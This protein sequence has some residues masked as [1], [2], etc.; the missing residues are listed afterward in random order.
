MTSAVSFVLCVL[1]GLVTPQSLHMHGFLE[2]VL[3][4]FAWLSVGSFFVGLIESAIWGAYG[5][6]VFVPIHNF[7][8]RKWGGVN[9]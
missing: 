4:G 9:P 2:A 1:W 3:P 8:Y 6:I 7:F 5:A